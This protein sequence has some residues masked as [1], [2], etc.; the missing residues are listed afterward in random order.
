MSTS[1]PDITFPPI[2]LHLMVPLFKM[3]DQIHYEKLIYHNE[4]KFY[5]LRL[6]VSEFRDKY[7]VNIRKYFQ[8]YEGDFQASR[9]GVSMEAEM[10]NISALLEGLLEIVSNEE[11]QVLIKK[12]YTERCQ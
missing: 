10:A 2:N 11:G 12:L 1:W 9:E 5:Q 8:T 7:Y 3:A 4:D 6:T